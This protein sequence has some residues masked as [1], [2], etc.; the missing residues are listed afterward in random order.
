[1]PGTVLILG[2][3]GK[4]GARLAEAFAATWRVVGGSGREFDAADFG[5][6]TAFV[7]AKRPDIIVNTV[8][9][10]GIDPCEKEPERALTLNTLYPR[11]LAGLAESRG[12]PL[13]HFSTDAVF[14]GE[15]GEPLTE[16]DAAD[17]VNLYGLTKYG[18]DCFVRAAC[19]RHYLF[20]VPLLFGPGGRGNQF[21][22]R[23]IERIRAG[24]DGLR[25]SDDIVSSPSYSRDVAS[26]VVEL[27]GEGAPFGTYHLAN[28]GSASLYELIEEIA[29][30]I[31]PG[32]TIDKASFRDFP[33]M[34]RKNTVTPLRSVRTAP[35]RPWRDAVAD[36]LRTLEGGD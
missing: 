4:L 3:T 11:H 20:R 19:R 24:Q 10:L 33:H 32:M 1:M 18:G 23:M 13:V 28:E 35:L 5:Q 17:P 16:E 29:R 15:T 9:F 8:A 25:V 6:V 14:S 12:I 27:V 26:R 36:Y 2:H 34:G 7:T 31:S 30:R 22:E 21:V